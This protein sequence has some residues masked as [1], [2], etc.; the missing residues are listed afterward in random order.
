MNM[1]TKKT[2]RAAMLVIGN[3]ILSGRTQDANIKHLGIELG[4]RGIQLSEVRVVADI[5][6]DIVDAINA[7]RARYTYVVTTGGIG[8]THDDITSECIAK[9][10]GVANTPHPIGFKLLADFYAANDVEFNAARQRMAH[11]PEGATLIKNEVSMAPG[12][13]MDNVYVMAGVPRIMRNMLEGILPLLTGGA[14]VKS[15]AFTTDLPEGLIAEHLK[16]IEHS[17]EGNI[18]IGSYP[19]DRKGKK[20]YIVSLIIRSSDEQAL[21][22]SANQLREKLIELGGKA[23]DGEVDEEQLG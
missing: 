1:T 15:H 2:V 14:V 8:P 4:L 17:F 23:V 21:A 7:L 9:A 18:D 10:F 11:T 20:G 16:D 6:Q 3:E 5:E 19:P 22:S 13:C 12:Y